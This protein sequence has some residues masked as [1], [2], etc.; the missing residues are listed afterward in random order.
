MGE[1]PQP[2]PLPAVLRRRGGTMPTAPKV[3]R[4]KTG[5]AGAVPLIPSVLLLAVPRNGLFDKRNGSLDGGVYSQIAGI[6]QGGVVSPPQRRR[7]APRI[8]GVTRL[9]ISENAGK[10]AG[11][12]LA[13]QLQ[14]AALGAHQR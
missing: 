10:I 8:T 4:R 12:A 13:G 11:V 5:W 6:E 9:D 2:A 1:I 14:L 7:A 3:T